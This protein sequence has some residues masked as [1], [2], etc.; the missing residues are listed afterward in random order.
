[1]MQFYSQNQLLIWLIVIWTLPWKGLALWKS[2][3]DNQKW[4]FIAILILNTLAILEILYIC[5]FSKKKVG[6]SNL[7]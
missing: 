3:Q 2:A 4:W 5:V 1:M 6:E 7:K